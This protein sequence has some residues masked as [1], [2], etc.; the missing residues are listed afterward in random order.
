MTPFSTLS[1]LRS[2]LSHPA[3]FNSAPL[4]E[5]SHALD[6]YLEPM[7]HPFQIS[8]S[9]NSAS[10]NPWLGKFSE[11]SDISENSD[12]RPL[13]HTLILSLTTPTPFRLRYLLRLDYF[14]FSLISLT[15]FNFPTTLLFRS[16]LRSHLRPNSNLLRHL[17]HFSLYFST[18]SDFINFPILFEFSEFF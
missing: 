10:R 13:L 8:T 18:S 6:F 3:H 16:H 5:F 14:W 4:S 12:L 7:P 15:S 1:H 11:N 2:V 17:R 9:L